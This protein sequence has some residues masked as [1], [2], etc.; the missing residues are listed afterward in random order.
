ML[1][2]WLR[3]FPSILQ[4]RCFQWK[5][6]HWGLLQQELPL[7]LILWLGDK[8]EKWWILNI[9]KSYF[10]NFFHS[11]IRELLVSNA[12][13]QWF[14]W[15]DRCRLK[16]WW[17]NWRL[18]I[19]ISMEGRLCV[20]KILGLCWLPKKQNKILLFNKWKNKVYYPLRIGR[21]GS[22]CLIWY[23]RW[24]WWF[25][26]WLEFLNSEWGLI[27]S[28]RFQNLRLWECSICRRNWLWF[29]V[30]TNLQVYEGLKWIGT[31][32]CPKRRLHLKS[33]L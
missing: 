25:R 26:I 7:W 32:F 23:V 1:S 24:S 6:F 12:K 22:Y 20:W 4:D 16:K 19:P 29:A 8:W 11:Q 27:W 14:L 31:W 21:L 15:E 2:F 3:Q 10:S 18:R 30:R 33:V 9:S 28:F 17:R 5:H 13:Q